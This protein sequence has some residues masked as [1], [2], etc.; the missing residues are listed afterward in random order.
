FDQ[1]GETA[2]GARFGGLAAAGEDGLERAVALKVFGEQT[3]ATADD[4][5]DALDAAGGSF[6]HRLLNER[7]ARYRQQ[8]F[9]ENFC[10]RQKARAESGCGD[11]SLANGGRWHRELS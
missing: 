10:G 5:D 2:Y 11:D 8:F 3:L 6:F 9:G 1:L 4:E 7:P